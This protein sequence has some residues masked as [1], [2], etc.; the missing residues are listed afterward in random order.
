MPDFDISERWLPQDGR[1][2]IKIDDRAIDF[3]VSTVPS[4]FG[5]KILMRILDKSASLMPLDKI[6]DNQEVMQKVRD[7]IK[8]SYG[9]IYVPGPAG[10]GKTTRLYSSLGEI[11]DP[12]TN[13][14]TAEDPIE[15]GLEGVIQ[16][17]THK[18][19]GLDFARVLRDFLR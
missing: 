12:G 8:E 13:I 3:R 2:S 1:I 17:Q 15:Y 10:S 14:S 18:A 5:E 4:K 11:N 6:I 9:I 19:F 7:M 16:I